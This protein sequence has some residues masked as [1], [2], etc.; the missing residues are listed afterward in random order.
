MILTDVVRRRAS[1]YLFL[2]LRVTLIMPA[3]AGEAG[4]L[5][6]IEKLPPGDCVGR[7]ITCPFVCIIDVKNVFYVFYFSHVFN[8]F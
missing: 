4:G 8:V 5:P 2:L 1:C 6:R 7:P 3:T